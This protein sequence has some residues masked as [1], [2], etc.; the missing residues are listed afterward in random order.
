MGKTQ[1]EG[2]IESTRWETSR[3]LKNNNNNNIKVT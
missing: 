1:A 3:D 2:M